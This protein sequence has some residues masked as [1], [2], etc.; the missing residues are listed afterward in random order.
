MEVLLTGP[1][2][3]EDD[4]YGIILLGEKCSEVNATSPE[5]RVFD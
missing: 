1:P 2:V 3:H 5:G 4:W